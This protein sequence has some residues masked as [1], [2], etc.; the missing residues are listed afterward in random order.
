[1]TELQPLYVRLRPNT[2]VYAKSDLLLS[3]SSKQQCEVY[4]FNHDS[5]IGDPHSDIPAIV[6]M[7]QHVAT[8]TISWCTD[9]VAASDLNLCPWAKKSLLSTHADITAGNNQ[10]AALIPNAIRIKVVPQSEGLE[11]MEEVIRSSALELVRLT[12]GTSTGK[13]EIGQRVVDPNLAIT[14]V[15]AAPSM[16][17]NHGFEKSSSKSASYETLE[18]VPTARRGS[19]EADFEFNSFNLSTYQPFVFVID[20]KSDLYDACRLQLVRRGL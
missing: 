19:H 18:L 15:V 7:A 9:F 6:Q 1:M 5:D 3:S 17:R 16:T 20:L 13:H 12:G 2:H 8:T 10:H 11:E 14:F 4:Y